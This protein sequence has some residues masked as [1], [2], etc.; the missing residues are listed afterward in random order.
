MGIQGLLLV[1]KQIQHRKHIKQYKGEKV[2]IDAFCWLHKGAYSCALELAKGLPTKKYV[3]YCLKR[4]DVILESGVI[5]IVVFDGGR[6]PMKR[7]TEAARGKSRQLHKN[8]GDKL[9]NTGNKEAAIRKYA[10][11][12]SITSHMTFELIKALKQRNIEYIVAPYEADAQMAFLFKE[13]YVSLIVTEDS[14]LLAFGCER[15]LF[16][17]DNEGYGYEIDMKNL[18]QIK[19][20]DF[21]NFSK[22]M[23]LKMCILSGCDYL[24]SIKGIGLKKAHALIKQSSD[25]KNIIKEISFIA[26]QEVPES[27]ETDF[28][29][30]FLTFKFQTV[31]DIKNARATSLNSIE[32]TSYVEIFSYK[33]K[34]FLGPYFYKEN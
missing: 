21:S 28:I 34:S 6:L 12:I 18:G 17:L 22:D 11:G 20:M 25:I 31:Y 15:V 23:F 5:P 13:K 29:R 24:P 7:N 33:D 4:F 32:G 30:A 14:D 26:K 3:E 9:W 16:K 8:E 19:D 10:G 1:L 2:A 27:Y